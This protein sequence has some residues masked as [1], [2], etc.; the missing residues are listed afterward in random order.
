LSSIKSSGSKEKDQLA[1]RWAF[2]SKSKGQFKFS[3]FPDFWKYWSAGMKSSARFLIVLVSLRSRLGGNH[4]NVLIYDKTNNELE[5]FDGLGY[6]IHE[7][8]D[9]EEL[10]KEIEAF[11]S[12]GSSMPEG[13]TYYTPMDYCPRFMMQ[14]KELSESAEFADTR[15]NCAVWRLW[16]ID[17]R[18][19]NPHL[20]R[21]QVVRYANK[22]V[23][24]FGS[25]QKFIK[26][27]QLYVNRNM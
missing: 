3:V 24:A 19:S 9:I 25:F 27:Y 20:N 21:Q 16:Y 23:E 1:I 14:Y 13:F 4:A 2:D 8:Y 26:A 7:S 10:D 6:Q 18:L 15:G 5:R 17:L 12:A 22:K 11:F